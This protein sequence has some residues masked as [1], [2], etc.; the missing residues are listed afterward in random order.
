L[1]R[2]HLKAHE[3]D[4][5]LLSDPTS[6]WSKYRTAQTEVLSGLRKT[7]EQIIVDVANKNAEIDKL[8]AERFA[9]LEVS[10]RKELANEREQLQEEHT[11]RMNEVLERERAH[12]EKEA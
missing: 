10:L 3:L 1:G 4:A 7:A 2:Q 6:A 12:A 9:E 11:A 8:R 5:A